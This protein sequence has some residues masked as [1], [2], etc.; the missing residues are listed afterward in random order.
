MV[1]RLCVALALMALSGCASILDGMF[2]EQARKDCDQAS[3]DR[4]GCYDRVD[5]HRRERDRN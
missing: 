4:S 1:R 3:R 5:Q 2:D